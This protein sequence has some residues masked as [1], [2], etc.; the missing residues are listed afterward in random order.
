M[1]VSHHFSVAVSIDVYT[2]IYYLEIYMYA[3][4]ELNLFINV[5]E[6]QKVS[7]VVLLSSDFDLILILTYLG[8]VATSIVR[9][10]FSG[11]CN[12]LQ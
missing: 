5:L 8:T 1:Q 2:Y 4:I 11:P 9:L 12:Y 3:S 7:N 6:E 10:I